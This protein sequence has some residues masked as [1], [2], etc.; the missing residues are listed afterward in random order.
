MAEAQ[1]GTQEEGLDS[2]LNLSLTLTFHGPKEVKDWAQHQ[3]DKAHSATCGR[4]YGH[5]V[6]EGENWGQFLFVS[7]F[8]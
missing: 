2:E 6:R 1:E 5:M 3:E 8:H 7:L 4:S